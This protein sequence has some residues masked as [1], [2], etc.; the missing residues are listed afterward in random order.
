[1]ARFGFGGVA[2]GG[3]FRAGVREVGMKGGGEGAVE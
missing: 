3:W 1:M 2:G